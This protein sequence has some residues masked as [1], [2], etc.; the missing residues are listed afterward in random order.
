MGYWISKGGELEMSPTQ[1]NL[2]SRSE[3]VK[4]KMLLGALSSTLLTSACTLRHTRTTQ[5]K[6]GCLYSRLDDFCLSEIWQ[7]VLHLFLVRLPLC[8]RIVGLVGSSPYVSLRD[9]FMRKKSENNS[10]PTQKH[11][12]R[13]TKSN[14]CPATSS[15]IRADFSRKTFSG[16]A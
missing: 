14:V 5:C 9:F 11:P 3:M 15:T 7:P 1:L 4:N 12:G 2:G 8:G 6:I 10:K 16:S 13:D